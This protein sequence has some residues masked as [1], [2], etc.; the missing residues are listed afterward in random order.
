MA[1]IPSITDPKLTAFDIGLTFL[2]IYD[3]DKETRTPDISL[4]KTAL[5]QLSYI[6]EYKDY[7]T[8]S[9][10]SQVGW[11]NLPCLF[12][13]CYNTFVETHITHIR[14]IPMTPYELRFEIF[15]Q[16][17]NMLNDQFSIEYDTAVRWN[18]VEKKE[19]TMDY[20]DFPTL[21]QVLE[22]AEII[23]DFVSSK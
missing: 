18:E 2:G 23:N 1:N 22:Q 10:K 16:A 7:K 17:Y 20:P 4:A 6:P 13:L 14:R 12:I 21:N 9:T 5:Y 8:H 15:K 3:G 11:S 19:V